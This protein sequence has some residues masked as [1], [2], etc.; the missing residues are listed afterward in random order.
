MQGWPV[1]GVGIQ[2]ARSN[3]KRVVDQEIF[4]RAA[5][6]VGQT[7]RKTP[8]AQTGRDEQYAARGLSARVR[9]RV[10]STTEPALHLGSV[11]FANRPRQIR[12]AGPLSALVV[13]IIRGQPGRESR[14]QCRPCGVDGSEPRGVAIAAIEVARHA[15][16]P[17]LRRSGDG[18]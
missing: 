6:V 3:G 15:A 9:R 16:E 1:E 18:E 5:V 12:Q 2:V 13:E 17:A 4:V 8:K 7:E 14:A 10:G 11:F